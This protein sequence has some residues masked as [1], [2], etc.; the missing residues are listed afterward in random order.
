MFLEGEIILVKDTSKLFPYV[1]TNFRDSVAKIFSLYFARLKSSITEFMYRPTSQYINVT[2]LF[3]YA[4][5]RNLRFSIISATCVN[6]KF[7]STCGVLVVSSALFFLFI[8][9]TA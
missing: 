4:V 8:V 9:F 5:A 2:S 7:S 3:A 1:S 6:S